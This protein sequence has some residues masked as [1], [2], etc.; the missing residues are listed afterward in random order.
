MGPRIGRLLRNCGMDVAASACYRVPRMDV[1]VFLEPKVDIEKLAETLDGL[2]HE[3]RVH[4]TRTWTKKQMAAIFD[5]CAGRP[6]SLDLL[7]PPSAGNNVEVI[8]DLRNTLPLFA[9]AQKR[10]ARLEGDVADI[11]GYN[12]QRGLARASEPGYFTVR[13]GEGDHAGELVIDYGKVPKSKPDPWPEIEPNDRGFLNG[14]V[15]G[16]MVDYLRRISEHVSIG[17]ATK[18]GKPIG[19]YFALVRRDPG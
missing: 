14:I 15:W 17:M 5:A 1:T 10:F 2:G 7:V 19:Q 8:H 16:G 18:K 4:A 12:R 6:I 13:A 11:G 3:G 9:D